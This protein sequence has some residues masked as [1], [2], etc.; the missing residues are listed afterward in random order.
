MGNNAIS[1]DDGR[2][3]KESCSGK[4]C[5][6]SWWLRWCEGKFYRETLPN[7]LIKIRRSVKAL[8][9]KSNAKA[10]SRHACDGGDVKVS[11]KEKQSHIS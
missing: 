7:L 6:I 9:A 8:A 10:N 11:C 2:D 1:H 5:H 3:V 4:K